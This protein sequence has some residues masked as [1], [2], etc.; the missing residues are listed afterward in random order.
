MPGRTEDRVWQ[1]QIVPVPRMPF[2]EVPTDPTQPFSSTN[3]PPHPPQEPNRDWQ[4]RE[5]Y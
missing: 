1:Q 4:H 5:H 2:N 3:P